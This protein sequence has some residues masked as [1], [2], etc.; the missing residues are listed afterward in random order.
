MRQVVALL[1]IAVTFPLASCAA[2]ASSGSTPRRPNLITA[3][4]LEEAQSDA[5]NL[6][7]VIQRLRPN[8][9]VSRAATMRERIDPVVYVDGTRF[10][11]VESLREIPL[12]GV[13]AILRVSAQDATLLYGTGHAYRLFHRSLAPLVSASAR[14]ADEQA[15][16]D[17]HGE[18]TVALLVCSSVYFMNGSTQPPV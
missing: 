1:L 14:L 16:A 17:P 13:I 5:Q 6:W 2:G 12:T 10:G 18:S 15:T 8:W 7:E 4:Q 9:L 3:A 11:E